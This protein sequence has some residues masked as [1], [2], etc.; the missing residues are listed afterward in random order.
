[1][2]RFIALPPSGESNYT[3][4]FP[5]NCQDSSALGVNRQTLR[6]V[7]YN[8]TYAKLIRNALSPLTVGS[9]IRFNKN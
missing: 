1:L 2:R 9:L 4:G 7:R 8:Q 6:E 5:A 3:S